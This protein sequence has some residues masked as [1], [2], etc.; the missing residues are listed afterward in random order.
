MSALSMSAFSMAAFFM[1]AF[2]M[3]A[4]SMSAFSM[5]AFSCPRVRVCVS[6]PS[7][8]SQTCAFCV[9]EHTMVCFHRKGV[10][11][12]TVCIFQRRVTKGV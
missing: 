10:F 6:A 8:V 1:S 3:S 2:S 12:N 5:S 4:F 9:P 11:P 7:C